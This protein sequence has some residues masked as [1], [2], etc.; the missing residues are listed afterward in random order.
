MC[1]KLLLCED[2]FKLEFPEKPSSLARTVANTFSSQELLVYTHLLSFPR[3]N[4]FFLVSILL[5]RRYLIRLFS[6][7]RIYRPDE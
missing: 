5:K 3:D 2:F 7:S 4:S 6:A 1:S